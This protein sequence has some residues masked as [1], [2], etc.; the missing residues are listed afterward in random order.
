MP[1]QVPEANRTRQK[2]LFRS[3]T[4]GTDRSNGVS[5]PNFKK[6]AKAFEIP[7]SKNYII[8]DRISSF[9]ILR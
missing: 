2:D 3:R 9:R 6:I 8:F 1:L 5:C 7:Y 4:L